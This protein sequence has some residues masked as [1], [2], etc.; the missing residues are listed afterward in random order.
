ME[1]LEE[2]EAA[3]NASSVVLGS[4]LKER[5]VVKQSG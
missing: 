2:P 4:D 5:E 3:D 1:G